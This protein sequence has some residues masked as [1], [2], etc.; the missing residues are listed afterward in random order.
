M[1]AEVYNEKYKAIADE[2]LQPSEFLE[3]VQALNKEANDTRIADMLST[4]HK[5]GEAANSALSFL[6]S[7]AFGE[8]GEHG[9]FNREFWKR[10]IEENGKVQAQLALVNCYLSTDAPNRNSAGFYGILQTIGGINQWDLEKAVDKDVYRDKEELT[11]IQKHWQHATRNRKV[12]LY[13][14][15][16]GEIEQGGFLGLGWT[17]NKAAAKLYATRFGTS[18]SIVEIKVNVKKHGL[19]SLQGLREYHQEILLDPSF[20][21]ML[22]DFEIHTV[23]SDYDSDLCTEFRI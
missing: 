17:T 12:K 5:W 19:C 22:E 18:G 13:R 11:A 6:G 4:D 2:N 8:L 16:H 21:C 7:Q 14:G 23:T 1:Y 20:V 3:R 9:H 15:I 10:Y